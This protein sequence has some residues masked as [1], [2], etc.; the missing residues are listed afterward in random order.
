M[1]ETGIG[2]MIGVGEDR[3]VTSRFHARQYL[4]FY[5]NDSLAWDRKAYRQ[6]VGHNRSEL[7]YPCPTHTCRVRPLPEVSRT[8]V[9]AAFKASPTLLSIEKLRKRRPASWPSPLLAGESAAWGPPAVGRRRPGSPREALSAP[10][11]RRGG[12][13]TGDP[14][15][16]R[17]WAPGR[18]PA[19]YD[20]STQPRTSGAARRSRGTSPQA[21]AE[22]TPWP[23]LLW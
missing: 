19:A 6:P 13:K 14:R 7:S 9:E 23:Y 1:N 21:R 12:R 10:A 15:K 8:F 3:S 18:A 11:P 16:A 17:S 2:P 5:H 4:L 22:G 20:S